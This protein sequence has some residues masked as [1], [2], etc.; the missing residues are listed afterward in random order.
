MLVIS[1]NFCGNELYEKG[2]L[3]ISPPSKKVHSV[4]DISKDIS[5]CTK[6]HMCTVCYNDIVVEHLKGGK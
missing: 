1:C 5:I 3:V 2:A 4:F 6:L